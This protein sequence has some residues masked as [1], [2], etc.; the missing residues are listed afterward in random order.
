M[1]TSL[2]RMVDIDQ[3]QDCCHVPSALQKRKEGLGGG[4]VRRRGA[5]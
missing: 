5:V 1:E 4:L 3:L 2:G